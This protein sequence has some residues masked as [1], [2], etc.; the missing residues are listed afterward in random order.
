[1][2]PIIKPGPRPKKI[3][4]GWLLLLIPA[5]AVAVLA[6][7]AMIPLRPQ[8]EALNA[9]VSDTEVRIEQGEWLVFEP[10]GQA[11]HTGLVIYP[12][13]RVDPRAYA[14]AARA[15]AAHGYLVAIVPMPL[16]L[17]VLDPEEATQVIAAFPQIQAWAVGGHSLGGAMAARYGYLN[18]DR[19]EGLVLLAAYPAASD[20]LSLSDIEVISIYGTLDGLATLDKI[21]SSRSLLPA[22][23]KW[24]AI[25]GGN[26][27]QFGWYGPQPGDNQA[28]LS[29]TGQTERAVAAVVD[30]L[31]RIEQGEP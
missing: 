13:G 29:H 19:I 16:N 31:A 9:L 5:F 28:K 30:L 17:A 14:P 3:R 24:V 23:T 20:N 18:P 26:H 8:P 22:D 1:M 6:I 27:A 11:A 25:E 12:G 4:K 15:V 2:I 21:E 10:A 7:W